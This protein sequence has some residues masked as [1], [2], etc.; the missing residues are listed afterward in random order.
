MKLGKLKIQKGLFSWMFDFSAPITLIYSQFNS[1]GKTTLLR[2]L[3]YSIGFSI[4][5]TK[6]LKME[7]YTCFLELTNDK[8]ENFTIIRNKGYC[9]I[10]GSKHKEN[11]QYYSI[12]EESNELLS[13]IFGNNNIN[14]ITNL[15][16]IMY[17]DQEKGWTL[18]NR[19]TVIGA[20]RFNIYKFIQGIGDIDCSDLYKQLDYLEIQLEKYKSMFNVASY[21]KQIQNL[22]QINTFETYNDE[23]D[24]KII[25]LQ[26]KKKPL[27]IEVDELQKVLKKNKDFKNYITNMQ[28]NVCDKESGIAVPVNEKTIIGYSDNIEYLTTK[29]NIL[30]KQI[31][32]IDNEIYALTGEKKQNKPLVSIANMI[33][34]FD[35]DISKINIDYNSVKMM[36]NTLNDEKNKI[37]DSI[38]Y[39]TK[40]KSEIIIMLK[41]L[42]DKYTT[43]LGVNDKIINK[44]SNYVFTSDLKSL[45]GAVFHKIVFSFKLAYIKCLQH[46]TGITVPIILDSP[47]GKEI[48]EANIAEMIEIL[49][50]DFKNHQIIIASIYSYQFEAYNQI[51]LAEQLLQLNSQHFCN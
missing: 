51:T 19:G 44:S 15:L 39:K 7:E 32:K 30:K 45:S 4:P 13:K 42:I 8:G 49:K 23:L 6:G 50:K 29:I 47:R 27:S 17:V 40:S 36:I 10:V 21:Q 14:I 37:E 16:G 31:H 5:N 25:T 34:Q 38:D 48:D 11:T 22:S 20:N 43:Q 1:A 2:F 26:L 9:S 46:Y 28:L 24:K 3:L 33:E 41:D 35:Q 12:P 18:L